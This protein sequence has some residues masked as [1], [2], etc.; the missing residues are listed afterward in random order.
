MQ[1][2]QPDQVEE[3]PESTF[4]FG[5]FAHDVMNLIPDE[6]HRLLSFFISEEILLISII[7]RGEKLI[8][9]SV[10]IHVDSIRGTLLQTVDLD[11]ASNLLY[12]TRGV[13]GR[14]DC[15][16][17]PNEVAS[18]LLVIIEAERGNKDAYSLV[19][20]W[21]FPKSEMLAASR[22]N[23]EFAEPASTGG[24]RKVAE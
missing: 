12:I 9:H 24:K 19:E 7:H 6:Y 16:K 3:V 23:V 22:E 4:S 15:I 17:T 14:T 5:E 20:M 2:Q 18:F 21:M 8:E 1:Q 10:T 13:R 11:S